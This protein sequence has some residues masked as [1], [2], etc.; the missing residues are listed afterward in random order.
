[1]YPTIHSFAES[2]FKMHQTDVQ[3]LVE[4]GLRPNALMVRSVSRILRAHRKTL[5]LIFAVLP[6][7]TQICPALTLAVPARTVLKANLALHTQPVLFLR[8]TNL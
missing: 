2:V 6:F 3:L 5:R 7:R 4:V 1:M 8:A